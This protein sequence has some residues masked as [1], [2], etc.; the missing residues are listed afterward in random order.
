[1]TSGR[2][3]RVLI[4]GLAS[5]V[6]RRLAQRLELDPRVEK[7]VG[8]DTA[9]PRQRLERTEFV[10]VA[11]EP[12]LMAP[13]I[14]AAQI[15]TVVETRLP[16]AETGVAPTASLIAALEATGSP[17]SKL[18]FKSS[19]HYY[20]Y[21]PGAPAFLTED[22]ASSREERGVAQQVA[23]AEAAIRAFAASH[24]SATVTIVRFAEE[25]GAE[26]GGAHMRLLGLP[27]IPTILGFDP[28]WQLVEEHDV[29]GALAHAVDQDLPGTYNVAAD[30]V[31]ALS[32]I[33]QLLQKPVLPVV[34]PFGV[35]VALRA[36][37]R[38]G[39]PAPVE[40]LGALRFGRGLDN[41]RFKATGFP[42]RY[43]T[44]EAIIRLGDHHRRRPVAALQGTLQ[45]Y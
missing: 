27:A 13:I 31:L 12:Q 1:M 37:R 14:R 7:V 40:L 16:R 45:D 8:I 30:G 22:A 36:L 5:P 42:Y 11:A 2:L 34:P 25:V 24:P 43:T 32:E 20:G 19:A 4:T 9:A 33:A 28:R 6:G 29:I 10:R 39:L 15:D 44:R 21:G 35:G 17:P 23:E 38:A 18:V 41:R 26:A 3:Q